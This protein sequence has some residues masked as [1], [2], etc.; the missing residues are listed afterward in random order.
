M[1]SILENKLDPELVDTA[2]TQ[3][4]KYHKRVSSSSSASSSSSLFE[5]EDYIELIILL[6]KVPDRSRLKPVAIPVPH[7]VRG[8]H[9]EVCLFV[10][11]PQRTYKDLVEEQKIGV[12]KVIGMTKLKKNYKSF[13]QKRQLCGSYDLFLTDDRLVSM[14]PPAL[15]KSF[16]RK[17]KQPVPIKMKAETLKY[18]VERVRKSAVLILGG[19]SCCNVKIANTGMKSSQVAENI[20]AGMESI[21]KHIPRKW[22]NVQS[23]NLK[24]VSSPS[25]P[26]YN[27]LPSSI[28]DEDDVEPKKKS[29][30]TKRKAEDREEEKDEKMADGYDSWDDEDRPKKK[31]TSTPKKAP[32]PNPTKKTASTPTRTPKKIATT[33][34]STT[35]STTPAKK[36]KQTGASTPKAKA[37]TP[38]AKTA[39][40][41]AK[42]ATPK[43]KTATPK[44]KTATPKAKTATP[45]SSRKKRTN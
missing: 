6:K 35:T 8:D 29:Q 11:D 33:T 41:K 26:I 38:K 14:M 15:G 4:L 7:T 5:E 10:K 42:T 27:S 2:V 40:P 19:G 1:P 3:L 18:N 12:D 39:T 34:T 16:F 28:A 37:S 43:A 9:I 45:S 24:L 30:G 21:V 13:E 25:L 17:K 22:K 36:G 32:T 31:K 44:A 23:V 20:I